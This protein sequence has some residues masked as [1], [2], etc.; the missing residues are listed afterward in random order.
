MKAV[1]M[2]GVC[3][4]A[5]HNGYSCSSRRRETVTNGGPALMKGDS[6]RKELEK[7]KELQSVLYRGKIRKRRERSIVVVFGRLLVGFWREKET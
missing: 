7:P 6:E 4:S 1:T 5:G 2:A 3:R